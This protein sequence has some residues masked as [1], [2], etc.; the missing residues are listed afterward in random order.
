MDQTRLYWLASGI[1]LALFAAAG[2]V[3]IALGVE[4]ELSPWLLFDRTMD[5]VHVVGAVLA[6]A[7]GLMP[8]RESVSKKMA[9]GVGT[10]YL[11]LG[12]VGFLNGNLYRFPDRFG[13][14]THLELSENLFHLAIGAWGAYVATRET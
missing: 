3:A 9:L 1:A 7:L 4:T 2:F 6:L 8:V 14:P 5:M 13:A 11:A 10:V 12:V